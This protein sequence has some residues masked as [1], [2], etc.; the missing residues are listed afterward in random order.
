MSDVGIESFAALSIAGN[1]WLA[2]PNPTLVAE[3]CPKMIRRPAILGQWAV[4]RRLGMLLNRPLVPSIIFKSRPNE[5]II[6]GDQTQ[7]LSAARPVP[8]L[9]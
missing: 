7:R 2:E 4:R 6:Q 9:T 8:P 1:W 5:T 3:C